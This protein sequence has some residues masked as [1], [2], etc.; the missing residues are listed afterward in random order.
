[1][2]IRKIY[3]YICVCVCVSVCVSVYTQ[4]KSIKK[5]KRKNLDWY[6]KETAKVISKQRK[7]KLRQRIGRESQEEEAVREKRR[8]KEERERKEKKKEKEIEVGPEE[9]CVQK[10]I[11]GLVILFSYFSDFPEY[12]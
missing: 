12:I 5:K 2:I 8:E 3:I 1:M 11:S 4:G 6:S 7:T 10:N 9:F